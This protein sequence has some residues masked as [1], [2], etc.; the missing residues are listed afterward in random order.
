[1]LVTRSDND[2][3][4]R[5]FEHFYS[6]IRRF[7][8]Y[9]V[10]SEHV[11]S[12]DDPVEG[13]KAL[14]RSGNLPSVS[15]IEP[16]YVDYPPNSFC[17]EPPSDI[18]NSQS[19]IRDLVEA[20]VA[21][22]KW[23]KTL[24]LITYDE[25]GGFFDHIPP[26]PAVPVAPGMLQTT[27]VR[28]PSFAVSPWIKAGAV[29]GS[30][31][32]HFD[33]TS[34]LK[35]IARRFLDHNYPYL[36]ARYAAAHDLSEVLDHKIRHEQFRPFI[37]YTLVYDTSKMCLDIQ[38]G[39]MAV[40]AAVWQYTPNGTDA[41]HFRFEDA[42][43]GFAYIRTLAGLYLTA[44][45]VTQ[46]PNGHTSIEV[47]QERKVEHGPIAAEHHTDH[48]RWKLAASSVDALHSDAYAISCAAYPGK[49]LQPA[50]GSTTSGVA[51]VLGEPSHHSPETI[52]N[53]WII[54]SPLLPSASPESDA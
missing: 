14:A 43:D 23:D 2:V 13:F 45:H 53:P 48:Q 11:V 19:F 36:G 30:D 46:G 34:I 38:G 49:V 25:H 6:F 35:T 27:G 28:V 40:G 54:Q 4:W 41:Q 24:L 26:P 10:G 20:V 39:S 15:F 31:S 12:Y 7:E 29:F 42:G 8:R 32:L 3:T 33:H 52:P 9:T 22:P 5:C 16:H 21:G 17:D 44:Q 37:P 51:V 18:R 1:V 50:D 47:R